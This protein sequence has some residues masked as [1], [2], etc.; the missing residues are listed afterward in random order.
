M[1]LY[2]DFVPTLGMRQPIVPGYSPSARS[3]HVSLIRNICETKG[4]GVSVNMCSC[5]QDLW[6]AR[7]RA[8]LVTIKPFRTTSKITSIMKQLP[9]S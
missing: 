8:P 3:F 6:E 4:G 1:F 2:R 7:I 9:I 5:R